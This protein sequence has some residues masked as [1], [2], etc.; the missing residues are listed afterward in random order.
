MGQIYVD[1]AAAQAEMGIM[2]LAVPSDGGQTSGGYWINWNADGYL[3]HEW[4]WDYQ[5]NY[6]KTGWENAVTSGNGY[7]GDGCTG[8]GGGQPHDKTYQSFLI[9]VQN[10]H[11]ENLNAILGDWNNEDKLQF[12]LNNAA[13]LSGCVTATQ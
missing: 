10:G 2:T 7:V 11:S 9:H 6:L 13:G 8:D 1:V 12:V 5:Y 4:F 3:G